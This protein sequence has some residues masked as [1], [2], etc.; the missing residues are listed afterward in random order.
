MAQTTN[1]YQI[2]QKVSATDTL[3]LHPETEAEVVLYD[4]TTSKLQA[5]NLQTAIDKVSAK[6]DTIND[7]G[8]VT[9][10]KGNAE[11]IFRKGEVNLTPTNIGAE[12][13]GTVA[14]HN[15]NNTA[16]QD[17]RTAVSLAQSKAD[18][19]VTLAEGRARA[20]SFD[21]VADMTS[22][23]KSASNTAYKVGDNLFI[24]AIG[25]PDYWVS[26]VLAANTGTYG[27]YEISELETQ[28]VDLS[29]Y[30][31]K[32]DNSLAT[33]SKTVVGAIGEV[34]TT[35]DTAKANAQ[36]NATAIT[37][38]V[39]G[40]TKVAKSAN[41]DNATN[42]TSATTSTKWVAP[43]SIG[44]SVNSGTKSDGTAIAASNSQSVDGSVDKTIALTLGDSGI[45]VGTYSAVQVNSKGIAVAGG[46]MV[47]IGS[48]GQTAPSVN[49]ATGGLFFKLI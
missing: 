23:L 5:T 21:T 14:T 12:P 38:I 41:A 10:I 46:Q 35:A 29:G 9:G 43:R 8:V 34:K 11:T 44:V 26:G 37:N 42:A 48:S 27:Y 33:T 17:I 1:N 3:L 7:G 2:I 24:K 49:L 22:A 30:Q 47:E 32:T 39:N 18:S 45:S 36:T 16:H 25:S 15:T 28:K 40:A 13:S 4:G 20:V 31:T 19:A 6:I